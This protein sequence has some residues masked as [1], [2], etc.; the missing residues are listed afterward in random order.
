[1]RDANEMDGV[2][3]SPASSDDANGVDDEDGVMPLASFIRGKNAA[4]SID[5]QNTGTPAKVDAWIDWNNDGDW[6]DVGEQLL[7]GATLNPS[8]AT[9]NVSVPATAAVGNIAARFRISSSGG[10][11]PTGFAIDGAG[12]YFALPGG[13]TMPLLIAT[14][15]YVG[16]APTIATANIDFGAN[17]FSTAGLLSTQVATIKVGAVPEPSC[18]VLCLGIGALTVF[19]RR[20]QPG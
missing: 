18:G 8:V 6:S 12:G 20:R 5:V 10:L 17:V 3:S 13:I 11:T 1:M 14:G 4:I 16:A 15:N 2:S 9:I 19:S 7:S